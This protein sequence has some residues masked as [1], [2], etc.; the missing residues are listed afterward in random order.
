MLRVFGARIKTRVRRANDSRIPGFPRCIRHA[1]TSRNAPEVFEHNEFFVFDDFRTC[2]I[3]FVFEEE[4]KAQVHLDELTKVVLYFRVHFA[5]CNDCRRCNDRNGQSGGAYV[6]AQNHQC[7]HGSLFI[8]NRLDPYNDETNKREHNSPE[9]FVNSSDVGLAD[10]GF[11]DMFQLRN[12]TFFNGKD[13]NVLVIHVQLSITLQYLLCIAAIYL[14]SSSRNWCFIYSNDGALDLKRT[15]RNWAWGFVFK[16]FYLPRDLVRTSGKSGD[17]TCNLRH[18]RVF[19]SQ[20]RCW[21]EGL[22]YGLWQ[23]RWRK[24]TKTEEML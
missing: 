20:H 2:Q 5:P 22:M 6:D 1:C 10:V 18:C 14:F 3:V 7:T 8:A 13:I 4:E 21:V 23:W 24:T 11:Y 9:T 17:A 19:A 15:V 12:V 16:M